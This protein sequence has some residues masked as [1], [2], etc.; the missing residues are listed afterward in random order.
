MT[1]VGLLSFALVCVVVCPGETVGPA[2]TRLYAAVPLDG[3]FIVE[4]ILWSP[5]GDFI[6]IAAVAPSG[7]HEDGH[8]SP[9]SLKFS[10]SGRFLAAVVRGWLG[11]ESPG[12]E[13]LWL[14]DVEKRHVS[15][16]HNGKDRW[17][18]IADGDI[19]SLDPSWTAAEDAVVYGD[20]FFG[21]EELSIP[22]AK[23]RTIVGKRSEI[24]G[25]L[26]S[27][28]GRWIAFER[29]PDEKRDRCDRCF[30]AVSRDGS[31][32]LHLP[33]EFINWPYMYKAW[34]PQ[35]DLLAVLK[36]NPGQLTHDLFFWDL[37]EEG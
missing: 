10:P 2:P 5:S 24:S 32:T 12:P 20:Y 27:P 30:G 23:R 22:G 14:V 16:L 4:K 19:Q 28:T 11:Y 7:P 31:T 6:L 18:Q 34:H 9:S 37:R 3:A 21:I 25:V 8:R 36:R 35:E 29:W 15:H 26:I 1:L 33:W 13:E 17:W